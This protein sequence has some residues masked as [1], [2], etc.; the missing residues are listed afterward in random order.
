MA[1]LAPMQLVIGAVL[2]GSAATSCVVPLVQ[3]QEDRLAY[4]REHDLDEDVERAL[5][6][7]KVIPGMT[8]DEVRACW[9]SP[10]AIDD[11]EALGLNREWGKEVWEY[12]SDDVFSVDQ[13]ATVFFRNGKVTEVSPAHL[14]DLDEP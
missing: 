8:R 10:S 9:G 12:R 1:Q 5:R 3:T 4:I 14:G 6:Q 11:S 13:E 7:G 2:L